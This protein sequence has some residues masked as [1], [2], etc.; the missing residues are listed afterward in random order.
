MRDEYKGHKQR[1]SCLQQHNNSLF[2]GSYDGSVIEWD[3]EVKIKR[4]GG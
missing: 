2:S 4:R 1:V 3:L